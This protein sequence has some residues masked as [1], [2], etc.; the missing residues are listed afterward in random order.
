M[1]QR[2]LRSGTTAVSTLFALAVVITAMVV[3]SF[4][5]LSSG[6]V[7]GGGCPTPSIS[8]GEINGGY[9]VGVNSTGDWNLSVSGY[10]SLSTNSLSF[11]C[12]YKGSGTAS[13]IFANPNPSGESSIIASGTKLDSSASPLKV[14]VTY[15]SAIRSNITYAINGEITVYEG[16]VS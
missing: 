1:L 8:V 6:R 16:V 2:D 14:T 4:V 3:G 10:R 5:L 12:H 7:S 11:T 9:I 15:G 13:L